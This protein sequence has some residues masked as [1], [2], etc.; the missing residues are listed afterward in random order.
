M[1]PVLP[2]RLRSAIYLVTAVVTPVMAYLATQGVVSDFWIGLYTV[3]TSAVNA[4]A[5]V[6]VT[7]DEK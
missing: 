5:Y 3:F 6:N 4:L 7:P 2:A 1:K